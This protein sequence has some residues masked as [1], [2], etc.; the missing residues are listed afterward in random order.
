MTEFKK[1]FLDTSPFIYYLENNPQYHKRVK[2]FLAHCYAA[3][4]ELIT[5]V[6]TVAEYCVYPYR[7][8]HDELIQKFYLF[9]ED[10]DI[11]IVS[12]D[13]ELAQK[14]A[15]IRAEYKGFKAM[16]ALQLATACMTGCDVFLTNDRQ[17]K[18][19]TEL[20]CMLVEELEG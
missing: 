9:L 11:D 5:S 19:F 17:L 1:V 3:E 18:Q 2:E 15:E 20:N 7:T 4:K 10:M 6:I 13:K 16:D 14:A 8:D 12:I